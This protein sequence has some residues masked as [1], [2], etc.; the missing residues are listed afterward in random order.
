MLQVRDVWKNFQGSPVLRGVSLS[1]GAGEV[2]G[3]AGPS[4]GGKST[5]LRCIEGLETADEGAIALDGSVGFMFQDF[6]LF[7]HMTVRE[8]VAYALRPSKK[9]NRAAV[10]VQD[11]LERLGIWDLRDRYPRSLSGGQKQ[12][13]A[14]ARTLVLD[15]DLLLCDEPT[16]GLDAD[17]TDGVARLL[18]SAV[19]SQRAIL[20]A[21]HDSDFLKKAAD[22]ILHMQDGTIGKE[23]RNPFPLRAP[24]GAVRTAD[25]LAL[26]R[27]E[28]GEQSQESGPQEEPQEEGTPS[29]IEFGEGQG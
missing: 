11:L 8:N 23:V 14:L 26:A 4:G 27:E 18:R 25:L 7:P 9:E 1:V 2:V 10:R 22:R 6:Q 5:L 17:C 19:S 24:N 21:S 12:R 20:I 3:L 16:S 13:T 29:R 15:P 28:K